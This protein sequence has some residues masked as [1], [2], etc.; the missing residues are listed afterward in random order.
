MTVGEMAAAQP[1]SVRVF[2]AHEIDFCCGGKVPL[3]DACRERGIALEALLAEIGRASSGGAGDGKD[4][5]GADPNDLIDHIL[6]AHHA[7]LKTQLPRLEAMLAKVLSAHGERHGDVL[8]P[9]AETFGGLK[10][11]LDS[12]LM[13]EEMVL[14]PLIRSLA[15]ARQAGTGPQAHHCGSVRNPL[16]V[17][18][19]EHESAGEALARMR[20][21]TGGYEAPAD[22]CNT[23]RA[24]FWELA[25]LERDL[26]RHIHLENNILFPQAVELEQALAG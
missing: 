6:S 12:H 25:Q 9:L 13:K 1:A 15:L 11:E 3:A 16:R 7:Y 14:F 2:E 21:L 26:H 17:M 22:A 10:Q 8:G 19:M 20:S 23:L 18:L 5:T 24:V 4:W